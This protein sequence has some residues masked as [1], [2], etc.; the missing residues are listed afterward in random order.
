MKLENVEE[1][2][3]QAKVIRRGIIEQVYKAG[4]GHPG[5]SLS[6]ADIMTVLY[7]NELNIDEENPKWEDRDRVVL[8][9]G[10]CVPALY[11]CLANRGFF[12]FC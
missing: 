11:S 8:S 9:K 6:I 1:L 10:H 12:F 5:G 7:F 3:K 2:E 4:S